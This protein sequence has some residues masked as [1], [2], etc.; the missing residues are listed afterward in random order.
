MGI[1]LRER[2]HRMQEIA[3][4]ALYSAPPKSVA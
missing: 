1:E 3:H 2:Y 4:E